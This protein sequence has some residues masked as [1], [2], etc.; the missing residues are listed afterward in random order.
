MSDDHP[1]VTWVREHHGKDNSPLGDFASEVAPTLP[2][3]GDRLAL[4][5]R[6]D[7]TFDEWAG[8]AFDTLWSEWE[9]TG[10]G[11]L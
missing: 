1:F 2:S 8:Q 3:T 6:I 9:S 10:G 11:L 4:R 5:K 7:W